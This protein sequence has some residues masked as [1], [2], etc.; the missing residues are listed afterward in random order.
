MKYF[1]CITCFLIL[2]Q[3]NP[4]LAQK[5]QSA[6]KKTVTSGTVTDNK[7]KPVEGAEIF[8]DSVY[9]GSSTDEE[10]NYKIK[11]SGTPKFILAAVLEK[12]Y[13]TEVVDGKTTV[14][15]SLKY[16]KESIPSYVKKAL[17]GNIGPKGKTK[18]PNTYTDIYQMIRQEVP[19][20][21]VSG[22]SIVIQQPNSFFG[23]TTPLFVVN[24]V[25]VPNL[26]YV[27]PQSVKSIELL[28]GS[29]AAIYGSEG[30]NGVISIT[31]LSGSDK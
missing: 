29:K 7:G 11:T 19:G 6:S 27:N 1:I 15:I 30:A 22:R 13:G 14:N 3:A 20:V 18:K 4:A 24:G 21:L 12:G 16:I 2:V 10:G 17:A 28:T 23:S 26:D 31:L 5:K 9:T 8:A 25:R